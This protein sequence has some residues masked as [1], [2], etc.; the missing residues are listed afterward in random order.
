[1]FPFQ[2]HVV[3]YN[4][5]YDSFKE[6]MVHPDG[7]AVLGAFLEVSPID[8]PGQEGVGAGGGWDWGGQESG[9]FGDWQRCKCS[10]GE[11]EREGSPE[12]RAALIGESC[13]QDRVSL[14][15]SD[16]SLL[17]LP[18]QAGL[19]LAPVFFVITVGSLCCRSGQGRTL[20]IR[21]YLSICTKSKEKV[22][23]CPT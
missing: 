17:A 5:K 22:R 20:T 1:M 6:A 12:G 15:G 13:H 4:T 9:S 3:H 19:H 16:T 8:G 14:R 7:L 21:K 10:W 23:S 11:G 18:S 2:I